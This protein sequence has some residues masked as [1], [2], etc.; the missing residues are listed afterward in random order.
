MGYY[1]NGELCAMRITCTNLTAAP[2]LRI[3]R[4][5]TGLS[6]LGK[7]FAWIGTISRKK[8]LQVQVGMPVF[9]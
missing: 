7:Y 2:S 8:C 3:I 1:S 6:M 5:E 4:Y 9:G